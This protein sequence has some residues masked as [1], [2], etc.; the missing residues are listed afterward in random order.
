MEYDWGIR[1]VRKPITLAAVQQAASK[2]YGEMVK[3]VVDLKKGILAMGGEMH[4]DAEKTLLEDGSAQADLWG[5]NLVP[6][7]PRESW[8]EYVSL[9]N[10]KPRAGNRTMEIQDPKM[11]E[12][13]QMVITRLI[14]RA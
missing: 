14:P 7:L 8:I 6:G 4:A 12:Q 5:I 11:R 9:I 10:I 3:A 1:I 2:T 13:I